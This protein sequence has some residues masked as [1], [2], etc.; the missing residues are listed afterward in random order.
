MK[1]L[2]LE[3]NHY[4]SYSLL[5]LREGNEIVECPFIDQ[6]AYTQL[7][8]LNSFDII[9][10]RIGLYT[11]IS[12]F[13]LQPKLKF[14]VTATTGLNHIDILAAKER[15]IEIIS[16]RGETEFLSSITST[17]EHTWALL[18][19][20]VRQLVPVFENVVF[21]KW[22]RTPFPLHQLS[23]MTLGIIGYGRLG[24][25]IANYATAFGMYVIYYDNQSI[26]EINR[27][28]RYS[29]FNDVLMQS[30]IVV[31][32]ASWCDE[33]NDMFDCEQFSLMKEN[34]YFINTARGEMVNESALLQSL[35]SNHLAGAALDVLAGDSIWGEVIPENQPLVAFSKEN[36]G[37]LIITSHIGGFAKEA[38]EKTRDFITDK[39]LKIKKK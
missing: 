5:K 33:N 23:G 11:G 24:K 9:F 21:G 32:M 15:N 3:S 10:T 4:S 39:F 6:Q 28:H 22:E 30:D 16:L 18:L 26:A 12:E 19:C 14:L 7:L 27:E 36:P 2:H 34:S 17:A 8:H 1:I 38:I 35:K 29:S 25:I 13:D 37:K 31:L 20:L